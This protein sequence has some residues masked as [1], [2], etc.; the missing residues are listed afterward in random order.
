M[1][2]NDLTKM[3][4]KIY[5]YILDHKETVKDFSLRH[6]AEELD[7]APASVLRT[8]NRLGY[9]H[10]YEFCQQL[11]Q[12][13]A[14]DRLDDVTYQA[15]S[16]FAQAPEYET[17]MQQFLN[18]VFADTIFIFFGVGTSGDLASY[19]ARQFVNHG[20]EAFVISDPFYPVQLGKNSLKN[21]LLIVLSASGETAQ[22]LDQVVNFYDHNAKIV[23]ITN[24]PTNSLAELSDLNFSYEI[25]ERIVGQGVNLTS[26]VPVVYL[27][28]R[29]AQVVHQCQ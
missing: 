10:Y 8:I 15:Q 22:T 13:V 6:L 9:Q 11:N 20:R 16:Y 19:G 23:S 14:E 3:Q 29:L 5:Q 25:P 12:E 17:Q 28:E 2:I 21:H 7:V 18:L 27:L 26:Q 24:N 4:Q 1:P